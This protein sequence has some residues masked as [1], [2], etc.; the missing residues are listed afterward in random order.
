M[1][2]K[3]IVKRIRQLRVLRISQISPNIK[4]ITFTS[5]DF[6][7]FPENENGGYVKFLFSEKFSD[8]KNTLVRPYTIRKFSKEKCELD[9]DFTNH[10]GNKGYA[11]KWASETKVGDK[12]LIS[13]P[14]LKQKININS[15][16]FFFVGDMTALPAISVHLEELPKNAVGYSVIETLSKDDQIYLKKPKNIKIK[17]VTQSDHMNDINLLKEVRALEWYD[18][19]P[20]VWVACEFAKMKNLRYFFQKEKMIHK[21]N[22]YISSY[23]KL[24][25]N[26]E[27]HKVIKKQDTLNWLVK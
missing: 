11:T 27:E 2:N 10:F 8:K 14:G 15:S 4:R 9:I 20:F 1:V 17:W 3:N 6:D 19:F 12:I 13:G 18:S 23:W 16:W 26:E 24:G 5:N 22:I 7:D 21:N 25:L